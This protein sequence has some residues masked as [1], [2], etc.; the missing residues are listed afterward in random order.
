[1]A[2]IEYEYLTK[3][4]ILDKE[5]IDGYVDMM[6]DV[7]S[8]TR[9]EI[10]INGETVPTEMVRDRFLGLTHE[11]I[12]YVLDS[13]KQN[14]TLISNIRAYTLTALYNAPAT[15]EQYYASLVRHDM[16]NLG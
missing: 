6:T 7:C 10:K 11:H 9:E 2:N 8:S 13:M 16:A 3:N 12:L 1:M 5:I 4:H 15:M 14:T